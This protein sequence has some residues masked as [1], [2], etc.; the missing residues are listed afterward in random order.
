MHGQAEP[1]FLVYSS[2]VQ[3]DSY[4]LAYKDV[5]AAGILDESGHLLPEPQ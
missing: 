4:C 3:W 5:I 2:M 1:R